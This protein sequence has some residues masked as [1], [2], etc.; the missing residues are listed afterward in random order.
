M[1]DA[2][3]DD[4]VG[5]D[6]IPD[7]VGAHG[8]QLA[9]RRSPHRSPSMRKIGQIIARS[10]ERIGHPS[11]SLRIEIEDILVSSPDPPQ[12]RSSPDDLH[13]LRFGRRNLLAPREPLQ[14]FADA[15]M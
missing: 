10:E 4:G 1:P 14:P 12:S 13:V 15:L 8:G 3:D 11:R 2:E 7:D 6:A 5:S 9:H